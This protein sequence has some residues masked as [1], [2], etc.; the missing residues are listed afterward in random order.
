M[1]TSTPRIRSHQGS[2]PVESKVLSYECFSKSGAGP[3]CPGQS[4]IPNSESIT[5]AGEWSFPFQSNNMRARRGWSLKGKPGANHKREGRWVGKNYRSLLHSPFSLF[6]WENWSR[7][8]W[9]WIPKPDLRLQILQPVCTQVERNPLTCLKMVKRTTCCLALN[10]HTSSE[11]PI[12][13]CFTLSA[14]LP[15]PP[16]KSHSV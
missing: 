9:S 6:S 2:G 10:L 15:P 16:L 11:M 1:T 3:L 8:A 13:P 5:V 12:L 4:H 7:E 14:S